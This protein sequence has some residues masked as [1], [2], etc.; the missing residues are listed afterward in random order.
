MEGVSAE[1]AAPK[2]LFFATDGSIV[3]RVT[4]RVPVPGGALPPMAAI[5]RLSKPAA[6]RSVSTS[7]WCASIIA[8]RIALVQ[9]ERPPGY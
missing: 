9:N 2:Q 6:A 7:Q 8:L 1:G 3:S 4:A 5:L